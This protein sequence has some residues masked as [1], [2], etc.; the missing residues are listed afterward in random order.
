M[1]NFDKSRA[2]WQSACRSCTLDGVC[3]H[4]ITFYM[5]RLLNRDTTPA[6]TSH[7]MPTVYAKGNHVA[8]KCCY[9]S[10]CSCRR[11]QARAT[12]PYQ[13]W[14][15][16]HGAPVAVPKSDGAQSAHSSVQPR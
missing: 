16:R 13:H 3:I 11:A 8:W 4:R 5:R 9:T 14:V 2:H 15:Q 7:A 12:S 6:V 1:S 10:Q